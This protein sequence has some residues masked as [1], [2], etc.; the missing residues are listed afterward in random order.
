MPGSGKG[1]KRRPLREAGRDLYAPRREPSG[2]HRGGG[3]HAKRGDE[4]QA[5]RTVLWRGLRRRLV[6]SP[7]ISGM[8]GDREHVILRF[9]RQRSFL[10]KPV[11][12]GRGASVISGRRQTQITEPEPKLVQEPRGGRN[13]RR[14]IK[15]IDDPAFVR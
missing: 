15:G 2:D 1:A 3:R 13:C 10:E 11:R 8:A 9:E 12:N 7:L 14:R 4:A 5:G 6:A